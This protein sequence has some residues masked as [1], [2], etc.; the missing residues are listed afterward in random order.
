M[1]E[2]N[3]LP[4]P[5]GI[6][7]VLLKHRDDHRPHS[8]HERV[9][10]RITAS[11]ATVWVVYAHALILGL[12]ILPR[13]IGGPLANFDP[14]LHILVVV[15]AL[16]SIFVTYFVL[17]AQKRMQ[18]MDDLR[19]NLTLHFSLLE[20]RENTR[21][22]HLLTRISDKMGIALGEDEELAE[23]MKDVDPEAILSEIEKSDQGRP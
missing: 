17:I 21:I 8:L 13:F 10:E 9:F 2:S 22:M 15:L 4:T 20:E 1:P 23:L 19:A 16:E 3:K 5:A 12:W 18:R 6:A 14:K 11:L 7:E